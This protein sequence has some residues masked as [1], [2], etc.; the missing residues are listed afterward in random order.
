MFF[1]AINGNGGGYYFDSAYRYTNYLGKRFFFVNTTSSIKCYVDGDLVKT[2]THGGSNS[3]S[4]N[5][6]LIIG[7]RKHYSTILQQFGGGLDS[8]LMIDKAL[9]TTEM[10]ET[11]TSTDL[12]TL[13]YYAD[14]GVYWKT[15]E[16]TFPAIHG[17]KRNVDNI[18]VN[19][20]TPLKA[21]FCCCRLLFRQVTHEC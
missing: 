11:I 13:S 8:L 16:D 17:T 5:G 19:G 10:S 3:A 20:L 6:Q 1:S 18:Y 12:N 14:V 21:G 9:S 2:I 15:G 4:V 7:V